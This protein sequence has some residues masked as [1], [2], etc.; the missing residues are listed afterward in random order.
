MTTWGIVAT[1]KAPVSDTLG[2]VAYHL[3]QGAHHIYIYLDDAND[4]AFSRLNAHPQVT[5]HVTDDAWWAKRGRRP[6]KHR[7]VS[8]VMPRIAI[9]VWHAWTG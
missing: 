7:C 4:E 8:P 2:F 3:S 6:I 5:A 1:I 9:A